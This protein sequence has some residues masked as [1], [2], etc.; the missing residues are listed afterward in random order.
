MT[1][2]LW[3]VEDDPQILAKGKYT[4]QLHTCLSEDFRRV[5]S[6][7][8]DFLLLKIKNNLKNRFIILMFV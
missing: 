6:A 1:T 7:L 8:E 2:V 3:K 4:N 5:H